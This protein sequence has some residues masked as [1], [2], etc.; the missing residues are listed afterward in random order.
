MPVLPV[1]SSGSKEAA[2]AYAF[3]LKIAGLRGEQ[4]ESI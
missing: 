2:L 4:V 1:A 3:A